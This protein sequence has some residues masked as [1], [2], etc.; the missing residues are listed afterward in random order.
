MALGLG[1]ILATSRQAFENSLSS[2][3]FIGLPCP[4]NNTGIGLV[5]AGLSISF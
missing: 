5:L 1:R 2:M 3:A 4:M